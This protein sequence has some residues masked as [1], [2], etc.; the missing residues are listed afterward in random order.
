MHWGGEWVL[1]RSWGASVKY[2]VYFLF[3]GNEHSSVKNG[4]CDGN[5]VYNGNKPDTAEDMIAFAQNHTYW[6]CVYILHS[7]VGVRL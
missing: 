7:V 2:S 3:T 5:L 1:Q 6:H 4:F